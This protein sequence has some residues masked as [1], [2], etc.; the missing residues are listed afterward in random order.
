MSSK[1]NFETKHNKI[2][3]IFETLSTIDDLEI[4]KENFEKMKNVLNCIELEYELLNEILIYGYFRPLEYYKSCKGYPFLVS[5]WKFYSSM[6]IEELGNNIEKFVQMK[7]DLEN[8]LNR[9]FDEII[10][11]I[12]CNLMNESK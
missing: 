12:G 11:T 7:K 4:S 1:S 3:S 2:K 8:D 9:L 5:K 6:T 10:K